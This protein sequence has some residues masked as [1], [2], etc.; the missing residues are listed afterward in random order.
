MP[1]VAIIVNSELKDTKDR[2]A[3]SPVT[4]KMVK[5]LERAIY[6]TT[7]EEV[8]IVSTASLWSNPRSLLSQD[9]IYCPLTIELP[10]SFLFPSK[11]IFQTCR[12]IKGLRHWV[13]DKL[14][15]ACSHEAGVGHFWLPVVWTAKGPLYGEMIGET[16]L[17]NYYLQPIDLAD[18]QR[19]IL[20]P[21]AQR[22]LEGLKAPF[23]TYLL[24][25]EVRKNSFVFDRLWP[26]PAA[27]AIASVNVQTPDLFACHW[28]CL[29]QQP[30]LDLTIMG[31]E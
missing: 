26:F 12:N 28:C 18:K 23:A 2:I 20:Y 4:A 31:C 22:L 6:S 9:Y 24:Q 29:T 13:Q 11:E 8:V 7:R 19:Q 25:L 27:P 1:K 10:D 3:P 21:F 30:I 15:F 14:S 16:E 5:A 17:P